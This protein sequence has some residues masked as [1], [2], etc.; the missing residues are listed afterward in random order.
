MDLITI[1][2]LVFSIVLHEIAHGYAANWLGD[3]T[4]RLAGRLSINPI[5]HIDL[6]GSI[7][8]PGFLFIT[9]SPVL[10][11][12]A[13][14]VPYNPYNLQHQK[15]GEALV[16]AAGPA[17]NLLIALIFSVLIR[18]RL[19]VDL[20]EEFIDIAGSIVLINIVLALFNLV[21]IPPLDGS[22]IL[23]V[24][25]PPGLA[26]SYKQLVANIQRFGFF[27]GFII[28]FIFIN[29]FGGLFYRLVGTVFQL[30]TGLY[31]F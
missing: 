22:K 23:S 31:I 19:V 20:P 6:I 30:F 8:V 1:G 13:K 27:G 7:I 4:A 11:G 14:P 5:A 15:W 12:W 17:V 26:H 24:L 21:P 2:A 9:G 25:L 10:L 3:P 16:A 28:I 18:L 29:L